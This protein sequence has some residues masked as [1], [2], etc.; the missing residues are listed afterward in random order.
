MAA[1]KKLVRLIITDDATIFEE[2]ISTASLLPVVILLPPFHKCIHCSGQLPVPTRCKRAVT[3]IDNDETE[4]PAVLFETECEDCA[5][6]YTA[7]YP[8]AP[9]AGQAHAPA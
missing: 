4:Y 8:P 9:L 1:F 2:A 7:S 3:Y 6:R 5:E